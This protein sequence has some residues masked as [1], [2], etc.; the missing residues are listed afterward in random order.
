MPKNKKEEEESKI[1]YLKAE[2]VEDVCRYACSFDFNSGAL[3]LTGSKGGKR[4]VALGEKV[5]NAQLAYYA[6]IKES[7]NIIMYEPAAEGGKDKA[8]FTNYAGLPNKY[9][10][11]VMR[12]DLGKIAETSSITSKKVQLI[13]FEN[14]LDLIG[15][16][17]RK[18]AKEETI[19][20]V[21]SFM[22]K[23]KQVLAAFN[24]LDAL[25]NEK[26]IF[27]YAFSDKKTDDNFARYD[28]RANAIDFANATDDHA[29]LYAKIICLAEAF[30]FFKKEK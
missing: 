14:T 2:S 24:V 11:H 3:I 20:N 4:L 23:G 1:F 16:A 27:Y 21:Y 22:H 17:I 30:P 19:A 28:Y 26:P 29:Y 18:A 25:S 6:G 12:I 7:G 5:G 9:Y 15:A 13:K 10:I 8:T